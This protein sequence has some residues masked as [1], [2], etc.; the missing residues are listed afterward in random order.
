MGDV[1][2]DVVTAPLH[3][4]FTHDGLESIDG[5]S[6]REAI[7]GQRVRSAPYVVNGKRYVPMSVAAAREYRKEGIASWYGAETYATRGGKMTA[8]GEAFCPEA[9]TAAHK[10]LPLPSIVRVTNLKNGR[11]LVV[12]VNDRGPFVVDRLIDLSAGAAKKLGYYEEGTTRVL[13]EVVAVGP[14]GA[15]GPGGAGQCSS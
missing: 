1:A 7:R 14:C 4:S 2:F 10:H 13:V 11:V 5:V 3:W 9:L 15:T 12:R 8:N 6:P